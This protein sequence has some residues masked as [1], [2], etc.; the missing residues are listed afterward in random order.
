MHQGNYAK[1]VKYPS[2]R[3]RLQSLNAWIVHWYLIWENYYD[4]DPVPSRG[5]KPLGHLAPSR[6]AMNAD[7]IVSKGDDVGRF[8]AGIN[9]QAV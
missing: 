1:Y 3:H 9:L 6:S 7:Y 2:G 5:L 8:T 4:A